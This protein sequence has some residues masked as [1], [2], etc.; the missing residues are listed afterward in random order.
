MIVFL[1]IL[2][3]LIL[4]RIRFASFHDDY[5]GLDQCTAIRG[6][7]AVIIFLS[8]A[9]GYLELG[10]GLG[11]RIVNVVMRMIGQSMVSMFFFYSGYGIAVSYLNKKDYDR[12]FFRKR[13]IKT[14][15]HF[16]LAIILYIL[17]NLYF[18]RVYSLKTYLLSMIGFISIGN[19]NWFIFVILVLY[20]IT[21][22][23]F[24]LIKIFRIPKKRIMYFVLL[25]SLVFWFVM[26]K[27]NFSGN[28]YNTM[29]CYPVGMIY[30]VYQEQITL[31]MK[32]NRKYALSF[33]AVLLFVGLCYI[34]KGNN[35][36]YSVFSVLFALIVVMV[37]MKV[38]IQN[39]VLLWIGKYSFSI[40]ILQRFTMI[41]LRYAGI[42]NPLIFTSFAMIST[43]LM[44]YC[45][46]ILLRFVDRNVL[47]C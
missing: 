38:K 22:I 36:T 34:F 17:L 16:D 20:L 43:F 15:V 24:I 7:F 31:N 5:L 19:S 11:D 25:L 9:R 33:C 44:A 45:F 14:L 40:Y 46:E 39:Q 6:I 47:H 18:G 23:S 2:L 27:M 42:T 26:Y 35:I 4:Y 30:G 21:W 41:L 3:M 1:I 10:S 12:L 28:W 8:H 29:L 13:I 32:N 37:S